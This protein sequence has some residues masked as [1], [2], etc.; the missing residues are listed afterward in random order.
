[1]AQLLDDH[2]FELKSPKPE[3]PKPNKLVGLIGIT[4]FLFLLGVQFTSFGTS[5]TALV[6]GSFVWMPFLVGGFLG[7]ML[8]PKR[9]IF[10]GLVTIP[11]TAIF[12]AVIWPAL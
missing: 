7:F 2:E 10:F 8:P 12:Y 5:E 9:A 6:Q 4:I 11:V 3:V 1:M